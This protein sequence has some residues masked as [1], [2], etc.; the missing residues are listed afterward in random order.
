MS[1]DKLLY[2][3][4]FSLTGLGRKI[5]VGIALRWLLLSWKSAEVDYEAM[6]YRGYAIGPLRLMLWRYP[7]GAQTALGV[8]AYFE[9]SRSRSEVAIAPFCWRIWCRR[10]DGRIALALGPF[11][12]NSQESTRARPVVNIG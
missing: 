6:Q 10:T 8:I 12:A 1:W 4:G 9:T 7:K 3:F 11:R 2:G 5:D